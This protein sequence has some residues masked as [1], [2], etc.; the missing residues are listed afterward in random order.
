[1]GII[2]LGNNAGISPSSL[3]PCRVPLQTPTKPA[4]FAKDHPEYWGTLRVATVI[5][6][7]VMWK[8]RRKAK[9]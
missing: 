2:S 6:S 3:C 1:M 7:G 5:S 8:E 9:E 4:R